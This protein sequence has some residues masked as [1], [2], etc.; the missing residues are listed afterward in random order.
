MNASAIPAKALL[1]LSATLLTLFLA[2]CGSDEG[3][4]D[5]PALTVNA[6]N[7]I[8][9]EPDRFLSGTLEAGSALE[10]LVDTTA[11]VTD[12]VVAGETWSCVVRSLVPGFNNV[13]V[14]AEDSRGNTRTIIASLFYTTFTLERVTS[15]TPLSAQTV[16][17]RLAPGASITV[18]L[19]P[20]GAT[21]AAA[22]IADTS[23][24][25]RWKCDLSG[26]AVGS[27]TLVIKATD[28]LGRAASGTSTITGDLIALDVAI[29]PVS[30]PTRTALVTLSGDR[31]TDAT[32]SVLASSTASIGTIDTTTAPT[33]WS[34]PVT[35]ARGPNPFTV[36]VSD[37][38]NPISTAAV[39]ITL[40]EIAPRV[41]GAAISGGNPT[42]TFSETMDSTSANAA[43]SVTD[44]LGVPVDGTSSYSLATRSVTFTPSTAL[45]PG[46]A[47]TVSVATTAVDLAGNP[48]PALFERALV[49]P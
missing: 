5:P 30:T 8:T 29:D 22:C 37:G 33:R 45:T 47:Y 13:S 49:A 16:G 40:D 12:L 26:L 41:I 32:I 38:V 23:Q 14:V 19:T 2:A 48:L 3:D 35:L 25:T 43:V 44:A 28:P 39:T 42:A 24:P 27:N 9:V 46:S 1:L 4:L 21:T 6:V 36:T 20:A 17:G 18:D 15:P 34:V 31:T 10:V 11:T 7:P